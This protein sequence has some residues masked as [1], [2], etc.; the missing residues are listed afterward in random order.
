MAVS[1]FFFLGIY[2]NLDFP[3]SF[4]TFTVNSHADIHFYKYIY[5]FQIL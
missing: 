2:K 5:F 4:I 1:D 3:L